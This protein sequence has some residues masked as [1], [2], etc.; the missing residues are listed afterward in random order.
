LIYAVAQE[1]GLGSVLRWSITSRTTL[2]DGLYQYDAI[3]RLQ[4]SQDKKKENAENSEETG[5]NEKTDKADDGHDIDPYISLGPLGSAFFANEYKTPEGETKYYP[6]ILLIDEIDKSD[7]DLPNDLLHVFEEGFFEIPEL[8]R[9]KD[10]HPAARIRSWGRDSAIVKVEQ[11]EVKCKAFPLVVMTSNGEREFPPAF[12]RR[13]LQLRMDPP[14]KDKLKDIVDAHLTMT[15]QD[16]LDKEKDAKQREQNEARLREQMADLLNEFFKRREGHTDKGKQDLA[17]D[18]LL[19]AIY[20]AVN[21]VDPREGIGP[22]DKNSLLD[23]LWR[24]LS[25]D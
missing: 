12:L 13:C 9:L 11:G 3:G 7:I 18:Q 24:P 6:R 22:K 2:K 25:G 5:N 10:I 1:L 4:A 20:L 8:V 16:Q 19:N 14:D 15:K 23:A 21:D 17:T